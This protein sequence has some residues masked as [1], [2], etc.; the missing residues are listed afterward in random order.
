MAVHVCWVLGWKAVCSGIVCWLGFG[1]LLIL[2][3]LVH[4]AFVHGDGLQHMELEAMES[5]SRKFRDV[6][7]L[8]GSGQGRECW[9]E[10]GC[11][12]KC[13]QAGH[14]GIADG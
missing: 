6:V 13:H 2:A 7:V 14:I 8:Q 12:C 11:M 4:M 10:E 3:C 1:R 9:T 5:E